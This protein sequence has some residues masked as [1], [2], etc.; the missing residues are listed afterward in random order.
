MVFRLRQACAS[1]AAADQYMF[2]P[3]ILV[4]PIYTNC[5]ANYSCTA[6]RVYLPALPRGESWTNVFTNQSAG[7][8]TAQNLSVA[9]ERDTFPLFTR[10]AARV[11]SDCHFAVQL[12]H[13]IPGFLSYS[14]AVFLK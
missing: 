12:N 6:R 7:G 11:I 3:S 10:G 8:S 1:D 5:S 2:G 14:V 9:G 13:F 4:A